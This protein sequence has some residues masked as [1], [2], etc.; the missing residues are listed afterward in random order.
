MC[1]SLQNCMGAMLCN[2]K[3]HTHRPQTFLLICQCHCGTSSLWSGLWCGISLEYLL[4]NVIN[5][6]IQRTIIT[7]YI[8]TMENKI[9]STGTSPILAE[10]LPFCK[11]SKTQLSEFLISLSFEKRQSYYCMQESC[12]I[13]C[14]AS[15]TFFPNQNHLQLLFLQGKKIEGGDCRWCPTAGRTLTWCATVPDLHPGNFTMS[16]VTHQEWPLNKEAV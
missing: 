11:D 9:S 13:V 12:I 3:T 5:T 2:L 7:W 15:Q 4:W 14:N 16:S 6:V 8:T 10:F 1:S